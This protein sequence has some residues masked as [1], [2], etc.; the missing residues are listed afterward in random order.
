MNAIRNVYQQPNDE[1]RDLIEEHGFEV[2][3]P[4]TPERDNENGNVYQQPDDEYRDLIEEYGFEVNEPQAVEI[5]RE[6]IARQLDDDHHQDLYDKCGF[7]ITYP[8]KSDINESKSL[9]P[10][11]S[12]DQEEVL[13][14]TQDL[15]RFHISDHL[16]EHEIFES[17]KGDPKEIE[18]LNANDFEGQNQDNQFGN[19]GSGLQQF[20]TY[21]S[22]AHNE[23]STIKEP[24]IESSF[25][26][27]HTQQQNHMPQKDQNPHSSF[28]HRDSLNE[29]KRNTVQKQLHEVIT[30]GDIE[31]SFPYKPYPAQI[32]YMEQGR[33]PFYV[34]YL[35]IL[36]IVALNGRKNALLQ[37]PT[38]TGKTLCMLCATLAWAHAKGK[39]KIFY[40]TR[41][42]SQIKQVDTK[43]NK[44]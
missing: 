32:A 11:T 41:T 10:E 2:N 42:H 27:S 43:I 1:Y 34:N 22:A 39:K 30:I 7:I 15:A 38:G 33:S 19:L 37:S 36:V 18:N 26:R 21:N 28:D 35:F 5:N 44:C 12:S 4:E 13:Q 14:V 3:Y 16:D 31:I 8:S 17:Q 25:G 20:I 24:T 6:N 29:P 23:P 9:P 40:C